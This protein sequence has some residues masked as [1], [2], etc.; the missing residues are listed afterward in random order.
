MKL[1]CMS[2][3]HPMPSPPVHDLP[4]GDGMRL[5]PDDGCHPPVCVAAQLVTGNV[6]QP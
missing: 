5:F 6:P 1:P 2:C 3:L 4:A